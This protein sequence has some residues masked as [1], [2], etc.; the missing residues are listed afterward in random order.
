MEVIVVHDN[1]P[2]ETSWSLVDPNGNA[3]LSQAQDSVFQVAVVVSRTVSVTPGQYSFTIDD[4]VGDGIC[5][6][7]G[8]GQYE[9]LI[10]GTRL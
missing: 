2:E 9:I 1:Y 6:G 3:L 10:G 7:Y 8:T 5:C 4:S